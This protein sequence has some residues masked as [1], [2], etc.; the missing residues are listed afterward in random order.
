MRQTYGDSLDALWER[1]VV[2]LEELYAAGG[3]L[4]RFQL[5]RVECPTLS[6]TES[7]IRSYHGSIQESFMKVFADHRC[8]FFLKAGTRSTRSMRRSSTNWLQL[9]CNSNK[10]VLL[11]RALFFDTFSLR[12][13]IW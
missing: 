12:I 13:P 4:Y 11:L 7:R 10:P 6:C 9:S 3:D 8:M 5:S 2:G 1:Y